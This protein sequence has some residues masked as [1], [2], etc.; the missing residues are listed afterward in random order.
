[1]IVI[2]DKIDNILKRVLS[3]SLVALLEMNGL[4]LILIRNFINFKVTI[5]VYENSWL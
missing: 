1:M 2:T 5:K 4:D 3:N